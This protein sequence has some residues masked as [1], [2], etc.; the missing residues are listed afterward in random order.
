MTKSTQ[1]STIHRQQRMIKALRASGGIVT[2]AAK[3]AGITPQT[4][5]NWYREDEQYADEVVLL[6]YECHEEFKDLVMEAVRKKIKEG[7]TTIIAMCYRSVFKDIPTKMEQGTPFKEQVRVGIKVVSQPV[8]YA[9]DEETQA[10]VREYERERNPDV[11]TPYDP[12]IT[13]SD[14]DYEI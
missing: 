6:K 11:G 8:Y 10:A 13:G 12:N 5:Y 14:P 9:M 2:R 4:H 7:N 1:F 3:M